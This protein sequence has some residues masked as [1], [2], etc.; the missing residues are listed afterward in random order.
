MKTSKFQ[1][2]FDISDFFGCCGFG[3]VVDG[4][5]WFFV[6]VGSVAVG[7]SCGLERL[8]ACHYFAQCGLVYAVAGDS[9]VFVVAEAACA[10]LAVGD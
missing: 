1:L 8:S 7:A 2:H 6:V 9:A 10:C 3:V 5:C 4:S